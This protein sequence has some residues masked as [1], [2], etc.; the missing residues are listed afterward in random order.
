MG[1]GPAAGSVPTLDPAQRN[2]TAAGPPRAPCRPVNAAGATETDESRLRSPSERLA[3]GS[4]ACETGSPSRSTTPRGA[5]SRPSPRAAT[6]RTSASGASGSFVPSV[7]GVG[8]N[9]IMA[10]T[11]TA[12]TTVW[13]RQ[14]RFM[15]EGVDGLLRDG[16]GPPGG[17]PG[18]ACREGR[19]D[20]H[21]PPPHEAIHRTGRTLSEI[22]EPAVSTVRRIWKAHGPHA[23]SPAALQA[24][25]RPRLRREAARRRRAPP[26]AERPRRRARRGRGVPGSRLSTAGSPPRRSRRAAARP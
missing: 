2:R 24:L 12:K 25:R 11:G 18:S 20:D 21:E 14:E 7:D 4:A 13:R 19:R 5:G 17:D 8:T 6:R 9:A 1:R 23:A 15:A 26:R 3:C 22:D 10:A 16:A